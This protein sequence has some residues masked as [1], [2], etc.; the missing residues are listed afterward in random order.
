MGADLR[1]SGI[2][3]DSA[4]DSGLGNDEG[5]HC[6]ELVREDWRQAGQQETEQ[7]TETLL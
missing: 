5:S 1:R 2:K 7:E 3:G 6:L 4:N